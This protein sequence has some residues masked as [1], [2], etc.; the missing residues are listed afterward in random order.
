MTRK[1]ICVLHKNEILFESD[2]IYSLT[3]GKGINPEV[4]KK[5]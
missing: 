3:L 2:H 4:I 1:R 5:E